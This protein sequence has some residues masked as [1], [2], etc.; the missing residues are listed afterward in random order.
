M[1]SV[2]VKVNL[3]KKVDETAE[4]LYLAW[5]NHHSLY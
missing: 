1:K 2:T 5:T 3:A 4:E